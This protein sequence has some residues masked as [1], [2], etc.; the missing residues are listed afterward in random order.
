MTVYRGEDHEHL[1]LLYFKAMNFL[2]L[3]DPEGALIECRRLNLR[4]NKL[5]DKYSSEKK[6]QR[7]AF[8][9]TLMGIIY[10][11]TKDY[12]NAFIAYRNAIEIY[13]NDYSSMFGL[14]APEQLKKD[15]LNTAWWTGF[16]DEFN[17]FKSL[18]SCSGACSPNMLL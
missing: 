11:S 1:M 16:V 13:E 10:Q 7:D 8:V 17:S 4:L 12:N 9:H 14:Q 5:S 15:L 3:N 2:K 6:F 18:F